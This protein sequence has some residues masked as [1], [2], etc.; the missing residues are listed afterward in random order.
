M[1]QWKRVAVDSHIDIYVCD[2]HAPWQRATNGNT[3]GL[4]RS[5]YRLVWGAA[6]VVIGS[7]TRSVS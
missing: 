5:T 1:G 3:Y 4:L 7:A 2:S 6:S